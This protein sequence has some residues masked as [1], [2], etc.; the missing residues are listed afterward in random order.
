MRDAEEFPR[1][2]N[3]AVA[4]VFGG[5]GGAVA[6]LLIQIAETMANG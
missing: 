1:W 2:L 4:V 3:Y 6:F 5:V